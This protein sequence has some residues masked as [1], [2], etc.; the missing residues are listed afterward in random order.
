MSRNARRYA[1][2]CTKRPAMPA[3]QSSRHIAAFTAFRFTTTPAAVITVKS[4]KKLKRRFDISVRVAV[5]LGGLLLVPLEVLV[6]QR[7][8]EFVEALLVVHHLG[9]RITRHRKLVLEEDRLLRANL[10]AQP[11][12]NAAEHVDVEGLRRFFHVLRR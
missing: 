5:F 12:V 1:S 9:A 10:L 2:S 3:R 8:A 11:A 4:A 6:G 7:A